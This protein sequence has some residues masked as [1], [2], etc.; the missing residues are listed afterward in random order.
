MA[1]NANI[2][3]SGFLQFCKE[4]RHLL[5]FFVFLSLLGFCVKKFVPIKIKT[6]TAAQNDHLNL[7]FVKDVHIVGKKMARSGCKTAI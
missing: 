6:H 3:I 1:Q 7:S 5:F 4:C 2:S